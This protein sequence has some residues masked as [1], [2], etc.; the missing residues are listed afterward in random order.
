M[1]M[2]KRITQQLFEEQEE[3]FEAA[4]M[5]SR[6][7][8]RVIEEESFITKKIDDFVSEH[9]EA[10][11]KLPHAIRTDSDIE[12]FPNLF[13]VATDITQFIFEDESEVTETD[14]IYMSI[15]SYVTAM[16]VGSVHKRWLELTI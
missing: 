14:K 4:A 13:N 10:I 2:I 7:V 12:D 16:I 3:H 1:N 8:L 9:E 11:K 15:Y 6:L 5:Y